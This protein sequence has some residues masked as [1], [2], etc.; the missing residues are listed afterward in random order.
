[1]SINWPSTFIGIRASDPELF[2]K[3]GVLKIY[4]KFRGERTCRN[5]ISLKLL[6]NFI[7]IAVRRGCS[8]NLLHIFR[9]PFLKNTPGRMLLK[10]FT[11]CK[12][13]LLTLGNVGFI[14]ETKKAR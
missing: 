3:K 5:V 10:N 9:T 2:L 4:N 12:T 14:N 11:M 13:I 1:M 6:C 8:V 7:E